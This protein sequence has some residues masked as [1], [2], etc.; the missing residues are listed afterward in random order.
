MQDHRKYLE[1]AVQSIDDETFS[2]SFV[3][4]Y[5]EIY[6]YQKEN[7][8]KYSDTSFDLKFIKN[9]PPLIDINNFS[10]PDAIQSILISALKSILEI[11]KTSNPGMSFESL[12][13]HIV[14][15]NQL[16]VDYIKQLLKGDTE[17]LNKSAIHNKIGYEEFIFVLI[18]WVKPLF[19]HMM[20]KYSREIV[21]EEWLQSDCPFCGYY[22]DMAMLVDSQEGKRFLHCSLCEMIWEYK[23]ISCTIC[24]NEDHT[25]MGY[26]VTEDKETP[27]RID[28]CDNCKGYI[29][30][31]R[32]PKLRD[33]SEF[34]LTVENIL[35]AN[36]D[37]SAIHKEYSRP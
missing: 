2:D 23:R 13:N 4:F 6:D 25:I 37:N 34:D 18:N 29:K 12:S 8:D 9:E 5:N 30:T 27:Y 21:Q 3:N 26:F 1:N 31:I 19:V 28:Y 24:G 33:P 11:I 17:E 20:D 14:D 32:I 22:P 36:L 16:A 7:Y 15:N 35:T 10:L